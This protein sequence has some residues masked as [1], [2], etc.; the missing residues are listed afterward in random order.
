M[1]LLVDAMLSRLA[2][3][4]RA[5]GHDVVLVE[6]GT[7]DADA[8]ARARAEER[9]VVT[10][11]ADFLSLGNPD[12]VVLLSTNRVDAAARELS[13]KLAL[14]WTLAPFSRCLLCN[15]PLVVGERTGTWRC[16][17]CAKDYWEGGHV[18]RMRA[19]LEDLARRR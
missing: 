14:D 7:S 2:R 1:K 15:T 11:D 10:C 5:A 13:G 3:W 17:T 12:R 9:V 8:L 18:V 6:G 16:T 19:R 4:L